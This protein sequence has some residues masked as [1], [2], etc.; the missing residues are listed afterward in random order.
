MRP[1]SGVPVFAAR[2]SKASGEASIARTSRMALARCIVN[3]LTHSDAMMKR[4]RLRPG[5]LG[6]NLK[7]L[8][9]HSN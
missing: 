3:T 8:C 2:A 1:H 5:K 7:S 6:G 9:Y 4:G